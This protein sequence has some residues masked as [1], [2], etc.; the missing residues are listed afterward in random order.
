MENIFGIAV[1]FIVL[2]L[3]VPAAITIIAR[4]LDKKYRKISVFLYF[5]SGFYLLIGVGVFIAYLMMR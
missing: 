4:K 2:M 3:G 1:V 5:M